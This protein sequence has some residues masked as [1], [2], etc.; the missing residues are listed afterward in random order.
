MST[1]QSR[2]DNP[3]IPPSA[4]PASELPWWPAP[5]GHPVAAPEPVERLDPAAT[6]ATRYLCAAPHLDDRF[7]QR[8]LDELMYQP[9]RAVAPSFGFS[10]GPVILHCLAARRRT[11]VRDGVIAALL[12]L[13]LVL[14]FTTGI[15]LLLGL[16]GL[17]FLVRGVQR[18]QDRQGGVGLVYLLLASLLVPIAL[19]TVLKGILTLAFWQLVVPYGY[20]GFGAGDGSTGGSGLVWALILLGVWGAYLAHRLLVHQTIAVELTPE[21]YDP[22][23]S[24]AVSLAHASRLAHV[25]QA[26]RGNVTIYSEEAGGRPF[27]GFGYVATDFSLVTPL[28][29]SRTPEGEPGSEDAARDASGLPFSI[30]ELYESV[31]TGLAG[32]SDDRL[33]RDEVVPHLAVHDHV[34][35]AGRLPGT[36]PYVAWGQPRSHITNA[37]RLE[38]QHTER[39]RVR[40][41]QAVRLAAWSG[42]LEV[43]IFVHLAVRGHMLFAEFVATVVPGIRSA[44]HRIDTYERLDFT[45]VLVA[46]GRALVDLLRSPVAVGRLARAGWHALS[47]E[48][49]VSATD[50]RIQR[51]L[52]FD[53]GCRA[54]VRELAADFAN[55]VQFQMYDANERIRLVQ[56]RVLQ[57]VV[58]FLE[59]HGYDTSDIA[60]QAT[61]VINNNTN[62]SN[63]FANSTLVGSPVVA[64]NSAL[65]GSAPTSTPGRSV[66]PTP[67]A[68]RPAP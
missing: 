6:A 44:Y 55:P 67:A 59:E 57:T 43:T 63:N 1:E 42:E 31:R 46:A 54:S 53:Y 34:F 11:L 56:R 13:G 26:Q 66:P 27:I 40:H 20:P 22:A 4:T 48:L 32:L 17:W 28:E 68:S 36:S 7:A 51:R 5:S 29:P 65:V 52:A 50:R 14:A 19:L 3:H 9:R 33:P 16:L 49:A 38:L 64:G 60:G 25:E 58:H 15:Q 2:D 61:T 10:L 47:R 8:V 35:V 45:S 41:Y 12:L 37:E 18:L 23:R 62:N 30:D 21:A 24:P 39:G